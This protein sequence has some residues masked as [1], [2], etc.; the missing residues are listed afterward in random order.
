MNRSAVLVP[1]VTL[2]LCTVVI[3]TAFGQAAQTAA[4]TTPAPAAKAK[5]AS[6]I[7][8]EAKI[9]VILG[10][11]NFNVKTKEIVTTYKIK[12]LSDAPIA[13]LK[14]DE[15]W[16]GTNKALASTATERYKQPFLPGGVIEMTTHAPAPAGGAGWSKNAQ[17]S[18]ANGKVSVK[19]V[20]QF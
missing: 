18:H 15:Y 4:P 19:V 3:S 6:P 1:A 2:L 16:Y 10:P 8:G 13:L 14:I 7:K 11:S 5:F 9:Q 17:F 12:N 20:K